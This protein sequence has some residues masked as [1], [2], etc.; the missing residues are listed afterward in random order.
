MPIVYSITHETADSMNVTKY[1]IDIG[2]IPKQI[3]KMQLD[4]ISR[5]KNVKIQEKVISV[6]DQSSISSASMKHGAA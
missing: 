3:S 2:K 6:N 5:F 1:I 4:T